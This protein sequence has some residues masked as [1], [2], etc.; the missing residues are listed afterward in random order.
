MFLGKEAS[1]AIGLSAL[2]INCLILFF[3]GMAVGTGIVISHAYGEGNSDQ[4][5]GAIQNILVLSTLGGILLMVLGYFFAPYYMQMC[6]RDRFNRIVDEKG[7]KAALA[8]QD[9]YFKSKQ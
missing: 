3:G 2:F 4:L 9:E 8:W 5:K 7:V 6:I 1:S